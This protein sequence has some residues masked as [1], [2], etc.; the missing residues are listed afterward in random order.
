MEKNGL[1]ANPQL[2]YF[3]QHLEK[4]REI[5]KAINHHTA[6]MTDFIGSDLALYDRVYDI[7]ELAQL[8]HDLVAH[9]RS[10]AIRL[11]SHALGRAQTGGVKAGLEDLSWQSLAKL[12]DFYKQDYELFSDKY[13]PAR[14]QDKWH[15]CRNGLPKE[16][17]ITDIEM[18]VGAK[19]AQDIVKM[20]MFKV[21]QL[22]GGDGSLSGMA[23][24]VVPQ[25]TLEQ[26]RVVVADADG[27]L[28]PRWLGSPVVASALPDN[29]HAHYAKF[30]TDTLRITRQR[31]VQVFWER[32]A[33]DR[34]LLWQLTAK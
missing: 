21:P 17:P 26:G 15:E 29:P 8:E 14:V 5:E 9:W 24:I 7:G 31:P 4:Y 20:D 32:G 13:S 23:G 12:L 16:M 2:D 30:V 1:R 3:I 34:V 33:K 28:Y 18:E 25:A 19:T 27:E 11:P 6:P 10:N 22:T